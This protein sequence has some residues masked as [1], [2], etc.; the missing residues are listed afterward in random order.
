MTAVDQAGNR[1]AGYRALENGPIQITVHPEW[2]L[3]DELVLAL[4]I[5]APWLK[6]YFEQPGG[7][8]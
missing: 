1:V 6:L 4:V 5:S 7:G 8:G 2:E 3:T